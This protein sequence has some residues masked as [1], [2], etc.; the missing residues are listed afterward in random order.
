MDWACSGRRGDPS[1]LDPSP[2]SPGPPPP[3]PPPRSSKSLGVPPPWTLPPLQTKAAFEGKNEIYNRGNLVGP[4]LVHKFLSPRPPP[5]PLPNGMGNSPS[6]GRPTPGVVKQHKSSGGSVDTTKTRLDPQRVRMSSGEGP[7][8]AAKGKQSDTEAL[9]QTP[10]PPLLMLPCSGPHTAPVCEPLP[11]PL[12]CNGG[13][14]AV[15][16]AMRAAPK[17]VGRQQTE[18]VGAEQPSPNG[19]YE[20]R[21]GRGGLGCWFVGVR[22]DG[23]PRARS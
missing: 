16:A 2:P 6:L 11:S 17:T 3:L 15:S 12:L 13:R 5:P 21:P 8:G 4:S 22:V 18:A 7:I 23:S 1:S 10:L 20:R 14:E 19:G 9:C